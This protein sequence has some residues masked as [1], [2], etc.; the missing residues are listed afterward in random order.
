VET[1]RDFVE[2]ARYWMERAQLTSWDSLIVSASERAGRRWLLSDGFQSDR[3]FGEVVVVNPFLKG[4][5][6]VRS[7]DISPPLIVVSDNF[8]A[9]LGK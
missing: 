4:A 1:T 3:R 9:P 7:A 5:R 8:H 2:R 6:T